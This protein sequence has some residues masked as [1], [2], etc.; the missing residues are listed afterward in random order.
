MTI[1]GACG[2]LAG[3]PTVASRP[4]WMRTGSRRRGGQED[5]ARDG[6]LDRPAH[7]G[8]AG[9]RG[10]ASGWRRWR[11]GVDRPAVAVVTG[12]PPGGGRGV[13][14][15]A[16]GAATDGCRASGCAPTTARGSRGWVRASRR[17]VRGPHGQR[18]SAQAGDE[19]GLAGTRRGRPSRG[20]CR[21]A[22]DGQPV[23][24]GHV[25]ERAD[26][27]RLVDL[28]AAALVGVDEVGVPVAVGVVDL[29]DDAARA[30]RRASWHQ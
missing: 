8:A 7:L 23:A 6:A 9:G 12:L 26:V 27:E 11:A 28:G 17:T 13:A 24:A 16:G 19:R 4:S 22:R 10:R 2:S 29:D 21:R 30:C 20:P 25:V 15:P 18:A 3:P 1:S 5:P 14:G